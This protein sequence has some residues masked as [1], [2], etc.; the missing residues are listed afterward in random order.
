MKEVEKKVREIKLEGVTWLG[1]QLI[2]MV[3]GLKKLRI[4]AQLV[5]VL[6]NVDD[7]RD[8]VQAIEGVQ[9]TDVVAFQMA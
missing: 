5:D 8:A 9:S 6:A 4:L 1:G 7:V 3:Y 2:D